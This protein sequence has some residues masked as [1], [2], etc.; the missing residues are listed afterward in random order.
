MRRLFVS[1]LIVILFGLR[2]VSETVSFYNTVYN[3][4]LD[5]TTDGCVK[6]NGQSLCV[7]NKSDTAMLVLSNRTVKE[8]EYRFLVRF[9]N[10][11]SKKNNH[12]PAACGLVLL[13]KNPADYF[14]LELAPFNTHPF[15]EM[16]DER[17]A[18][19][20]LYRVK[21]RDRELV[22]ERTLSSGVNFYDGLNALCV[23]VLQGSVNVYVGSDK[24]N[25]LFSADIP[26][27]GGTDAMGLAVAPNG[28]MLVERTL[29]SYEKIETSKQQTDWTIAKLD[30]YFED[31]KNPFEGYWEY[32]DR[33]MDDD[34]ARLGGKY[35]VAL[36]DNGNGFDIIYISGA[37]VKKSEW[38]EG[39][40]KGRLTKTI[41]T[42]NY[43]AY[44]I[45][46]TFRPMEEDVNGYFES[47]VILNMSFPV[48]KSQIRFSKVM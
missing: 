9:S 6:Q 43:N 42:D 46:S 17:L 27:C 12:S 23:D 33:D 19:V 38:R 5:F 14:L 10:A 22:N 45:D 20:S 15:D 11:K 8:K 30:A 47:G 18:K 40:L 34:V 25:K 21:G 4:F 16:R 41:F 1:F 3:S 32:L 44:W 26:S 39:M 29:L 35:R 48:Y 31:S 2:C 7:T 24:L 36:V 28:E 37:Q 13:Y